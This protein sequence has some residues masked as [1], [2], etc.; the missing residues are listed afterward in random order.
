MADNRNIHRTMYLMVEE[1]LFGHVRE[2][3][4]A[5]DTGDAGRVLDHHEKAQ[6]LLASLKKAQLQ[7]SNVPS[8]QTSPNPT[9]TTGLPG[10]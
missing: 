6:A 1:Y 3:Q 9:G 5:A 10:S 8:D 4:I 7:V 2:A